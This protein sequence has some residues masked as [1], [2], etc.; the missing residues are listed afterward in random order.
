MRMEHYR[1]AGAD[2]LFVES[3]QSEEEMAAITPRLK[4]PTLA[5]MVEGGRTPILPAARLEALGFR[6][7]IYPNSLT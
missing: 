5:N 4:A 3:P 1:E 2:V 6:L 7:A